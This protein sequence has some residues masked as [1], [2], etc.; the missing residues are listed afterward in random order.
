MN[1]SI[2]L[3]TCIFLLCVLHCTLAVDYLREDWCKNKPRKGYYPLK[4]DCAIT[5]EIHVDGEL[6][7][8]STYNAAGK[9]PTISRGNI[10]KHHRLF[11]LTPKDKLTI[12]R[13]HLYDGKP[14]TGGGGA[15]LAEGAVGDDKTWPSFTAIESKIS[16]SS[17][18]QRGG[19]VSISY[20]SGRFINSTLQSNFAEE[21]G[22]VF[23]DG[24]GTVCNLVQSEITLNS[25][26]GDGGAISCGHG[27][28][29]NFESTVVKSNQAGS[30]G[31]NV[32][33][34]GDTSRT[35]ENT[36][37]TF[38]DGAVIES[39]ICVKTGSSSNFEASCTATDSYVHHCL[40]GTY[41]DSIALKFGSTATTT[42]AAKI[43]TTTSAATSTATTTVAATT[44]TATTTAATTAAAT[45]AAAAT[46]TSAATTAAAA[47][48]TTSIAATT[49]ASAAATTAAA[50]ST[51]LVT[52]TA[53]ATTTAATT[54]A[55]TTTSATTTSATTAIAT[56]TSGGR[57]RRLTTSNHADAANAVC[58]ACPTGK[59]GSQ[60]GQASEGLACTMTQCSKGHY[61]PAAGKVA[62]ACPAGRFNSNPGQAAFA[63]CKA[64]PKGKWGTVFGAESEAEGCPEKCS[65]RAIALGEGFT[66]TKRACGR[67]PIG[68]KA[69]SEG[70]KIV[71]VEVGNILSSG[72]HVIPG[73]L[74]LFTLCYH[75]LLQM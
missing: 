37:C 14:A 67:C 3:P 45:T 28:K 5:E 61:C 69:T 46:T 43:T 65:A 8:Y 41:G 54:T 75:S 66:A 39:A 64:C 15:V 71:C 13:I 52:T 55:A 9:I 18:L 60:A 24:Y 1:L 56:T 4:S 17:A 35:A 31:K 70:D 11:K 68:K 12:Y 25:A 26:S 62:R 40:E 27:T 73:I 19:G 34:Y 51:S 33:C 74:V 49:T 10:S 2:L 59:F 50:T 42:A 29:C 44:V 53:A 38:S 36:E 58:T 6:E 72:S 47:A 48:S 30:V 23:C 57:R 16:G 63:A 20:G 21:G 7:I 22:A 32:Y